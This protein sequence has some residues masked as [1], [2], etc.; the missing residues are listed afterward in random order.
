MSASSGRRSASVEA[1]S[2]W[3]EAKSSAST[4]RRFCAWGS[5]TISGAAISLASA[6]V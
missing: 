1:S 2:G 5:A 3:A 4:R 6:S